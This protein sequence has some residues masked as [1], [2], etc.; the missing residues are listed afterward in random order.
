MTKVVIN[1]IN[2]RNWGL[3]KKQDWLLSPPN[4]HQ[5]WQT[6]Q[7]LI[8]KVRHSSGQLHETKPGLIFKP[9]FVFGFG[10]VKKCGC[11]SFYVSARFLDNLRLWSH[12]DRKTATTNLFKEDIQDQN[13][14]YDWLSRLCRTCYS[15]FYD[16]LNSQD[17]AS[18]RTEWFERSYPGI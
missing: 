10:C 13:F 6:L 12:L 1:L 4:A 17:Q 16:N 5:C 3:K 8:K 7:I 2:K 11:G 18:Q 9:G 15:R 14:I